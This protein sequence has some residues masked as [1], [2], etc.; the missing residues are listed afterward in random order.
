MPPCRIYAFRVSVLGSGFLRCCVH[1]ILDLLGWSSLQW[2]VLPLLWFFTILFRLIFLRGTT[3][4]FLWRRYPHWL[5]VPIG[6]WVF[7]AAFLAAFG[8]CMV[9]C[10]FVIISFL[11]SLC[12]MWCLCCFSWLPPPL[13]S[14]PAFP[15]AFAP[16]PPTALSVAPGHAII[17]CLLFVF[18]IRIIILFILGISFRFCGLFQLPLS[19]TRNQKLH[20]ENCFFFNGASCI[21][22]LKLM[23]LW[24]YMWE[25]TMNERPP[26]LHQA[27]CMQIV[28]RFHPVN[29][30]KNLGSK[31]AIWELGNFR[32]ERSGILAWRTE[33]LIHTK[34]QGL[35]T[36]TYHR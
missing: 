4:S 1:C 16:P 29:L 36:S 24:D 10:W 33:D 20:W 28:C 26:S 3:D 35:T 21:E 5:F 27:I 32:C 17:V 11:L 14:R 22:K 23:K 34:L 9:G 13:S 6:I 25:S 15:F 7:F 19:L 30:C 31:W 2:C 18:C 8:R 12:F